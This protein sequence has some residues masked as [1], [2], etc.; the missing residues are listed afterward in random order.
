MRQRCSGLPLVTPS[1]HKLLSLK[2][3]AEVAQLPIAIGTEKS[4]ANPEIAETGKAKRSIS[5]NHQQVI[6]ANMIFVRSSMQSLPKQ[7]AQSF[8]LVSFGSK[9]SGGARC[10]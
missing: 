10:L 6:A 1:L 8:R 3:I 2:S 5:A 7:P 4:K 9:C